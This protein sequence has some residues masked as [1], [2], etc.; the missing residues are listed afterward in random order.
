MQTTTFLYKKKAFVLHSAYEKGFSFS[1]KADAATPQRVSEKL[2]DTMVALDRSKKPHLTAYFYSILAECRD[3]DFVR[4]L[5]KH[6]IDQHLP[7]FYS[8]VADKKA[9]KS[10]NPFAMLGLKKVAI[11]LSN[12][13]IYYKA[14]TILNVCG[15]GRYQEYQKRLR[16]ALMDSSIFHDKD[17]YI[18]KEGIGN[19]MFYYPETQQIR[20]IAVMI[21]QAEK[22][23]LKEVIAKKP[24]TD[25]DLA[26][27]KIFFHHNIFYWLKLKPYVQ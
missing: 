8:P 10:S 3:F 11:V 18:S 1:L 21:K 19:I 17:Q 6:L 25:V 5:T 13:E 15:L 9:V 22:T 12:G 14:V 4:C 23:F 26:K 27:F 20:E 16:I 24:F 2:L 7:K